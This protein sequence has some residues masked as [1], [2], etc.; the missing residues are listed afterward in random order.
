MRMQMHAAVIAALAAMGGAGSAQALTIDFDDFAF[1]DS[2]IHDLT[3]ISE[4]LERDGF[5][6]TPAQFTKFDVLGT[7]EARFAGEVAMFNNENTGTTTLTCDGGGTFSVE[8]ID[9]ANILGPGTNSIIFH[10]A[11]H[12]GGVVTESFAF[13]SFGHLTTLVLDS[14]F[15]NLDSLAFDENGNPSFQFTDLVV[16]TDSAVPEPAGLTV[17]GGG[18]VGL[19]LARRRRTTGALPLTR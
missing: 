6:F 12:G 13:D 5:T 14:G 11:V 2:G 16:D 3:P 10:G 18:L 1:N 7:Q 4:T 19:L 15:E 8:S 9:V 17:L